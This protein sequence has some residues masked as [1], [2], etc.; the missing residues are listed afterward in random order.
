MSNNLRLQLNS[1]FDAKREQ[2]NKEHALNKKQAEQH[3]LDMIKQYR[4]KKE[5]GAVPEH[6]NML[7][8]T[9]ANKHGASSSYE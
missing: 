8:S 4:E 3:R 2:L 9:Y 1:E 6:S 5:N 7:T